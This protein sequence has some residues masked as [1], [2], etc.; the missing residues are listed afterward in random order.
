VDD[1]DHGGVLGEHA[2]AKLHEKTKDH[3]ETYPQ[4]NAQ[5]QGEEITIS[6]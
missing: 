1:A 5:L 4:N 3:R 6:L 2:G